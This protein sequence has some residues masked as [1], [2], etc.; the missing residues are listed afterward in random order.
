MVGQVAEKIRETLARPYRLKKHTYQCSPSIGVS[1][2]RG[3]DESVDLLLHH[4]DLAMYQ[5]KD[6][7]RNAV[8]FF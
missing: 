6:A 1:L 8:R 5:A 3:I 2:Y 4:A 7:G